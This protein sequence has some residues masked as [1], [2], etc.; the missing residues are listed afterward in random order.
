[1]EATHAIAPASEY[2]QQE[3][4]RRNSRAPMMLEVADQPEQSEVLYIY[5]VVN[6]EHVIN[7]PPFFPHL[8]IPACSPGKEFVSTVMP[9]FILERYE[10]IVRS[11]WSYKR[12]DGRK[13][14][15]SLLNPSVHPA[16]PW[17]AQFTEPKTH[18]DQAGNDL[19][20]LGCF[21][22]LTVPTNLPKLREEIK[23]AKKRVLS[24]MR[25]LVTEGE[26]LAAAGD[27][28]SIA[29]MHHFSMDYLG[30]SAPWHMAHDH[31]VDCPNCGD[32]IKEGLAY[33][34]NAFNEKCIIDW[35]RTYLAGAVKKEDVPAEKRWWD[36]APVAEVAAANN[37]PAD[38]D[39]KDSTAKRVTRKSAPAQK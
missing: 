37:A 31:M 23:L 32:K 28:K 34:R 38:G 36:E 15:T 4:M 26:K 13:Y 29:P 30:L 1:M 2:T 11:E 3:Q 39:G 12:V 8:F 5:N 24:K 9:R 16:S 18:G 21:W 35:E 25:E 14:A 6:K 33:H 10:N 22:S 19:N 20:A 27:L 17:E 7:Q